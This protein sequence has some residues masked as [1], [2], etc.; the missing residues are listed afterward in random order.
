M[1]S[2]VQRSTQH[3]PGGSHRMA[4]AADSHMREPVVE[5]VAGTHSLGDLE[6]VL[7][8]RYPKLLGTGGRTDSN[9]RTAAAAEERI[10]QRCSPHQGT[11]TYPDE[12]PAVVS[13]LKG[14]RRLAGR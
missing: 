11:Q 13:D 5:E 1:L 2:Y 7:V 9:R 8:S 14:N 4:P 3:K 12:L 10:R 6:P